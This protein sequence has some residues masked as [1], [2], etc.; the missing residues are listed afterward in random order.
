MAQ[1][2][3]S[4]RAARA[5]PPFSDLHYSSCLLALSVSKA[6]SSQLIRVVAF[7]VEVKSVTK[8]LPAIQLYGTAFEKEGQGEW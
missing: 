2:L 5:A 1:A 8:Q 4:A 6:Q 3:D 7:Q